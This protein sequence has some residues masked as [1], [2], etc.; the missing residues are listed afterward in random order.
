MTG[1][2]G[3]AVRSRWRGRSGNGPVSGPL[4]VGA[5]AVSVAWIIAAAVIHPRVFWLYLVLHFAPALVSLAALVASG[6]ESRLRTEPAGFVVRE[7]IGFVLPANRA[8][9]YLFVGEVLMAG[10]LGS[11]LIMITRWTLPVDADVGFA[12]SYAI[13]AILWLLL[14][15]VAVLVALLVVVALRGRPRIELTPHAVFV[16]EVLGSQTVP[17][18]ALRPGLSLRDVDR[19]KLTL[20]VDRPELVVRHGLTWRS[21]RRPRVDLQ[22]VQ[23]HSWFLADAIQFYVDHPGRRGAVGTRAE[24]ERLLTELGAPG[25]SGTG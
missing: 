13:V 6:L 21:A 11:Q 18:E 24:Y 19:R 14:L 7:G 1:A 12:G 8:F 5:M 20:A 25:G 16:A 3:S 2:A 9:S 22:H 23:V 15:I 10:Y 17:W 4:I